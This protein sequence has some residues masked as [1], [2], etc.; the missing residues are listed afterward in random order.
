LHFKIFCCNNPQ[1]LEICEGFGVS[2]ALDT[3]G[4]G[5]VA[6]AAAAALMLHNNISRAGAAVR[7][8]RQA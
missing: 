8:E 4:D 3:V 5:Q 6:A 1:V 7:Q 2:M